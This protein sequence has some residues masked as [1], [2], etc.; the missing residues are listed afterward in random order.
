[1]WIY[2][3]FIG[4]AHDEKPWAGGLWS[5]ACAELRAVRGVEVLPSEG[6]YI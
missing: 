2:S 4:E 3:T 5:G 6:G 1:M